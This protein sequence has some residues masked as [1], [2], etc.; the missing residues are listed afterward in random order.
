MF[1]STKRMTAS[2]RSVGIDTNVVTHRTVPE[3]RM[4]SWQ[5]NASM[6]VTSAEP[7]KM[8]T[9]ASAAAGDE[10]EPNTSV[11][12][13]AAL[14]SLLIPTLLVY[15]DSRA[16]RHGVQSVVPSHSFSL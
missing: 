12:N 9:S 2:C 4:F 7:P 3:K 11:A 15:V 8:R 5:P 14:K 1:V 10:D 13:A 6:F 16:I